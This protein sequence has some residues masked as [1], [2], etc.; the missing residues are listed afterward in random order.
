[1]DSGH[2]S[3][4]MLPEGKT[5]C[6]VSLVHDSKEVALGNGGQPCPERG[7]SADES[8]RTTCEG[9]CVESV[10]ASSPNSRQ[11]AF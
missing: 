3:S 2:E 1:M 8:Q 5:P 7:S 11:A 10:D 4:G 9:H 6:F